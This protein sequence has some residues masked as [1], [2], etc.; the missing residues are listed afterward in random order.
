[1]KPIGDWCKKPRAFCTVVN[2]L[3]KVDKNVYY[4][5]L[6][7]KLKACITL[8]SLLRNF[9]DIDEDNL[10]FD[11]RVE[12]PPFRYLPWDVYKSFPREVSKGGE[13]TPPL[14]PGRMHEEVERVNE[15][16][17]PEC[18]STPP[19]LSS[20]EVDSSSMASSLRGNVP[21]QSPQTDSTANGAPPAVEIPTDETEIPRR[22]SR[23]NLYRGRFNDGYRRRG[24]GRT[25]YP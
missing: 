14:S 2:K 21:S 9:H 6:P 13:T 8:P 11:E 1:M 3:R 10:V 24:N 19:P 17:R 7:E 16:G 4:D 22:S 25:R 20:P 23:N 15:N 5:G 18:S 12:E